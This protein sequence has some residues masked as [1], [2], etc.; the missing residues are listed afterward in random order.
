M[1][2]QS[3][4]AI[5]LL[6]LA[7][8]RPSVATPLTVTVTVTPPAPTAFTTAISQP[9]LVNGVTYTVTGTLTFTPPVS[10]GSLPWGGGNPVPSSLQELPD[11]TLK[12]MVAGYRNAAQAWT[13]DFAP[14]DTAYIEGRGWGD[15]KGSVTLAGV[16]PVDPIE[17]LDEEI[18]IVIPTTMNPAPNGVLL[19]VRRPDGAYSVSKGFNIASR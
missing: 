17:W 5:A 10:T 11:G 14:G 18:G 3:L 12:P 1:K 7:T 16:V 19:N 15:T 9:V 4:C 8:I 13:T 2:L 6:L